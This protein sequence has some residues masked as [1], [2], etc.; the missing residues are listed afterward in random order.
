MRRAANIAIVLASLLTS[1]TVAA[2][3]GLYGELAIGGADI[4]GG[5]VPYADIEGVAS[6]VALSTESPLGLGGGLT[7]GYNIFGYAAIESGLLAYGHRVRDPAERAWAGHW[8]SGIRVYPAWHWQSQLPEVLQPLEPSLFAGWGL[9]YQG[10]V[11]SEA[12]GDVAWRQTGSWRIGGRLEYF[13]DAPVKVGFDYSYIFGAHDTFI[14]NY[15]DND[16]FAVS[17]G[18]SFGAHHFSLVLGFHVPFV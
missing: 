18:A 14:L 12:L 1:T 15:E 7:L 3:P 8:H 4:S 11:P 10:N 2:R 9:T 5:N 16:T 13:F 17:P 6:G